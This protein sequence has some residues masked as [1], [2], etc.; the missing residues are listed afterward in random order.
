[1]KDDKFYDDKFYV[2]RLNRKISN[3]KKNLSNYVCLGNI[4]YR[5]IKLFP[6]NFQRKKVANFPSVCQIPH[7]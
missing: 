3:W 5:Y 2:I 1:M 6:R 4:K 7:T